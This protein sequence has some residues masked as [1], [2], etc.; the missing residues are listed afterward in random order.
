MHGDDEREGPALCF[1]AVF[2]VK[3]RI[4]KTLAGVRR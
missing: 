4:Q 1:Y 2:L 3:A